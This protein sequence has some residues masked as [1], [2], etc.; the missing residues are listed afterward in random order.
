VQG[1]HLADGRAGLESR[2]VEE[3]ACDGDQVDGPAPPRAIL[4]ERHDQRGEHGVVFRVP[5]EQVQIRQ[6]NDDAHAI[7]S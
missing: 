5:A 4:V 3:I 7:A 2:R 1:Q 6:V